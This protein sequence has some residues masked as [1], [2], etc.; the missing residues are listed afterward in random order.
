MGGRGRQNRLRSRFWLGGATSPHQPKPSNGSASPSAP[1]PQPS[2]ATPPATH[3]PGSP[4]ATRRSGISQFEARWMRRLRGPLEDAVASVGVKE[5]FARDAAEITTADTSSVLA[6]TL[7]LHRLQAVALVGIVRTAA[8]I[9]LATASGMRA[10]ELMELRIGCRRPLEEPV[11]GLSL[12][13]PTLFG[14]DLLMVSGAGFGE[15]L[16]F[17]Q[18]V[19]AGLP[20]FSTDG[21]PVRP[22]RVGWTG[23][24]VRQGWAV[25]GVEQV[26]PGVLPGP[27]VGQVQGD[28]AC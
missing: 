26:C 23:L 28:A 20:S 2:N 25:D 4:A 27:V 8:M 14:N 22:W 19:S 16:A 1:S 9:V 21:V 6:W 13:P 7:P 10:S 11:P 18:V 24:S 5:V 17:G 15:V 12:D 3:R